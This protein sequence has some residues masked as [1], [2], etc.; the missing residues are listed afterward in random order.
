MAGRAIGRL[1]GRSLGRSAGRQAGRS[2]GRSIGRSAGR[3]FGRLSVG[4][5]VCRPIAHSAGPSAGRPVVGSVGRSAGRPVCRHCLPQYNKIELTSSRVNRFVLIANKNYH[6]RCVELSSHPNHW[7]PDQ[8]WV[9]LSIINVNQNKS[10]NMTKSRGTKVRHTQSVTG[11]CPL[12]FVLLLTPF[13][14]RG[15]MDRVLTAD[16]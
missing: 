13:V 16:L 10:Q 4:R 12:D 8:N 9:P 5:S 6:N 15:A 2:L 3:L 11:L 14:N 7:F 1:A